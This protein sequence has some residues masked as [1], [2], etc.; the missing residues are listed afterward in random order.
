MRLKHVG[1]SSLRMFNAARLRELKEP[2]VICDFSEPIAAIVPYALYLEWQQHL[3]SVTAPT[4]GHEEFW[5]VT[6]P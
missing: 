5:D 2:V 4:V 3:E 6:T 1:V